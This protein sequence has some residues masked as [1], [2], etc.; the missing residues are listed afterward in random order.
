MKLISLKKATLKN[1]EA[2]LER[3]NRK[4]MLNENSI[5]KQSTGG[6]EFRNKKLTAG[7]AVETNFNKDK[8]KSFYPEPPIIKV[9]NERSSDQKKVG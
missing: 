4:F 8:V 5:S 7:I 1:L 3:Y 9:M 2:S 6:S